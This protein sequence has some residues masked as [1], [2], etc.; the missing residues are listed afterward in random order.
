MPKKSR[1]VIVDCCGERFSKVIDFWFS[2]PVV[3]ENITLDISRTVIW[4]HVYVEN[5]LPKGHEA[6]SFE[7]DVVFMKSED[8][9]LFSCLCNYIGKEGWFEKEGACD[10]LPRR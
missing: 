6:N 5:I 1:I 2:E 3:N 9:N 4:E 8:E 10:G 7:L